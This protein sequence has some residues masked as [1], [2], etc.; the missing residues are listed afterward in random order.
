[1]TFDCTR[2]TRDSI[3]GL[4]LARG[5]FA[6]TKKR[7]KRLRMRIIRTAMASRW[8]GKRRDYICLLS[9]NNCYD[10]VFVCISLSLSISRSSD[11]LTNEL[12]R[13]ASGNGKRK[14]IYMDRWYEVHRNFHL[15]NMSDNLRFSV[16]LVFSTVC[17][18][19]MDTNTVYDI[20]R[21]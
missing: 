3:V 21:M 4:F 12:K 10:I 5:H 14:E 13:N 17:V 9:L 18:R 15:Q 2:S 6:L 1:M 8:V 20:Y 7:D 19:G 16:C 11:S